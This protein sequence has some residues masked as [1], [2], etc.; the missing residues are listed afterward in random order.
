[1]VA[2][3]SELFSMTQINAKKLFGLLGCSWIFC[4]SSC[5]NVSNDFVIKDPAGTILSAEI[6]LCN[7]HVQLIRFGR[8]FRGKMPIT[9]EGDGD[10]LVHL[11]NGRETVCKIGYVTPGAQQKF[12]FEV[13]N[14]NCRLRS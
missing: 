9:C 4:L 1:M 5:G 6:R 11:S 10:I 3:E 13:E 2:L 7:K 8:E 12:Q 14:D